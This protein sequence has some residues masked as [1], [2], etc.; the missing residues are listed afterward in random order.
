M[1]INNEEISQ[2]IQRYELRI[3]KDIKKFKSSYNCVVDDEDLYQEAV[4][5]IIEFF[6]KNEAKLN[7]LFYPSKTVL[8]AMYVAVRLNKKLSIPKSS[9]NMHKVKNN[10][11][12]NI[13]DSTCSYVEPYERKVSVQDFCNDIT[14]REKRV[15]EM[16]LDGINVMEISRQTKIPRITVRRTVDSLKEKYKKHIVE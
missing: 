1:T 2:F 4:L 8:N 9:K 5:A 15:L 16:K 12:T 3:Y 7:Y 6:K 11:F 13:D 10:Q 14:E